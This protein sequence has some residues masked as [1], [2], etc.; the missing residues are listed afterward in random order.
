[1]PPKPKYGITKEMLEDLHLIQ[2]ITPKDIA[3]RLSCDHTL[4][5]YYIKKYNIKKLPKY[6]RLGGQKF[7]R[8]TVKRFA[9]IKERSA[10]WDCLCDCGKSTM[11][12]TAN[13][14]FGSVKSCGCLSIDAPTKHGLST[15]RQYHIWRALKTRCDDPDAINYHLYGGRGISYDPQWKDFSAFWEDMGESYKDG[16]TIERVNNNQNYSK[17]N[18]IWIDYHKQNFNKRTNVFLT[19]KGKK[20]TITEWGLELGVNRR[21]LYYLHGKGMTDKEIFDTMR[22]LV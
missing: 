9:G 20:Q 4:V 6:E 7:G 3:A 15:S 21:I 18:C 22:Y 1:M 14:R 2:G 19:H 10:S 16:L 13:L 5:L 17:D 8:L 12:T 11:A